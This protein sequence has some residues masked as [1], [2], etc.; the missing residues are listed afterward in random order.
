[1]QSTVPTIQSERLDLIPM[2]AEFLQA[3]LEG[4]LM[5]AATVMGLSI[6]TDW[7]Q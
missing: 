2:S 4:D 1:M 3:S 7:R 6:P 5:A